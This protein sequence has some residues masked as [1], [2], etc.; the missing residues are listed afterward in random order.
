M[1]FLRRAWPKIPTFD[2]T[3]VD[4]IHTLDEA[5]ILV[6]W[7]GGRWDGV[8]MTG[9]NADPRANPFSRG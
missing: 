3:H 4:Q 9:F 7:L 6:F 1:T 5:E 8:K 2:Q